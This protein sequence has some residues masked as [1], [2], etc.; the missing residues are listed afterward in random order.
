MKRP[1]PSPSPVAI[2]LYNAWLFIF[3]AFVVLVFV[4][5]WLV[6]GQTIVMPEWTKDLRHLPEDEW[7][8]YSAVLATYSHLLSS[9]GGRGLDGSPSLLEIAWEIYQ[10]THPY[11]KR[12]KVYAD[13]GVR[14]G[15][16]VLKLLALGVKAIGLGRPF[17]YANLYSTEGLK[18]AISLLSG[19]VTSAGANFGLPDIHDT[20]PS[21]LQLLSTQWTS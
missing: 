16:D 21:Y 1:S 5:A 14:Y 3:T 9:H 19:E 7:T 15:T 6:Q 12:S 10:K 17:I 2:G 11:L 18:R 20:D 8:T 4:L 13:G